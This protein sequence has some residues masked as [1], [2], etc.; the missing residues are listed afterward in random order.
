VRPIAE[1]QVWRE[2]AGWSENT[3]TRRMLQ[4]EDLNLEP[5]K[6]EFCQYSAFNLYFSWYAIIFEL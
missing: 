2:E 5:G 3:W 6:M 1:G 4:V